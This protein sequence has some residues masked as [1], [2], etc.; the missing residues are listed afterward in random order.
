MK[1]SGMTYKVE[2]DSKV[3]KHD[4]PKLSTALKQRIKKVIETKIMIRPE[5]VGKPLR[6]NLQGFRS[7]R[8]GDYRIIYRVEGNETIYI[9]A[10]RHRKD[11]Y[12]V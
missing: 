6:Q 8:V 5:L 4:I 2:F 11:V 12:D 1:M 10:I 3:V 9:I 7:C